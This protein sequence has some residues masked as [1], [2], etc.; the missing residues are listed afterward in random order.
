MKA[1]D[2]LLSSARSGDAVSIVLAGAPP[3]IALASTT[4]LAAARAVLAGLGPTHRGTDLEG[5][6][7]LARSLVNGL[8]QADRRVVLL[9]DLADGQPDGPPLGA[10]NDVP[11]WVPPAELTDA[12][13]NCALLTADRQRDRATVRIACSPATAA[14]GRAVQVLAADKVVGEKALPE[15]V[16]SL[17]LGI[18]LGPNAGDLTARLTGRDAIAADDEAP[19]LSTTGQLAVAIVADPASSKLVTGGAPPVEQALS[20]LELDIQ[21]RPLPLVPDRAD[22]LLAYAGIILEDPAGFTPEARRSLGTWLDRGGVALLALGP[23]APLAPLGASFEPIMQGAVTWAATPAPGLDTGSSSL[24]GPA[25]AGLLDL[26][27]RGRASVDV[28]SLGSSAKV[29]ARWKDGAPWLI[30]RSVGR[31]FAFVLSLP[32]SAEQSDLALRPAFLVLLEKFADAA[33]VRNGAHRT[34]VGEPWTFEGAKALEV[35]GPGHAVLHLVDEATAKIAVPEKIGVYE[36]SLDGD[37]LTRV[38]APIEREVDLRPRQVA[39]GA[40]SSSLGDVHSKIDLSPYLAT[41]LLSLLV[42]ELALR[43]VA[44]RSAARFGRTSSSPPLS[45]LASAP[46]THEDAANDLAPPPS[47]AAR[48]DAPRDGARRSPRVG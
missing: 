32:T 25:G 17:D 23:H 7:D 36:I 48:A 41:I 9:S 38:A 44:A 2:D 29:V 4:D 14:K 8:P 24:F 18:E 47:R 40:R 3:R 39:P 1:A 42:A 16:T 11:L 5:A 27:A 21:V 10:P 13:Q 28:A 33:R 35:V 46:P 43:A 12:A 45:S 31:G 20:A 6:L 30:E 15:Q 22:D 19:V 37:K 34:P 26:N